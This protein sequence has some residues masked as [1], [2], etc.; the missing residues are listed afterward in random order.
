MGQCGTL[1]PGAQLVQVKHALGTR[2][3][4]S[5]APERAGQAIRQGA[6]EAVRKLAGCRP[7]VI[8]AP[9]RLEI[10]LTSVTLADQCAII[11]TATRIAPRTVG[12]DA[13]S[14]TDVIGW[15]NTISVLS[16]FLR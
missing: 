16:A 8:A 15:I 14:M 9:Y 13:G 2:A 5:I 6:A 11:P 7:Y 1:F 10:D 3:A 12:F 4:R